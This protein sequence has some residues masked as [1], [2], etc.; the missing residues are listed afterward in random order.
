MLEATIAA[1]AT[2]DAAARAFGLSARLAESEAARNRQLLTAATLPAVDRYTG[3]LYDALDA[4]TLSEPARNWLGQHVRVHSALFGLVGGLDQ[5]PAY[6]C[7]HDSR[8]GVALRRHWH[9]LIAD[10]LGGDFVVDLRSEA[11]CHLGPASP[12]RS[13]YVRVV[14]DD[15]SGR[16]RALNHFNK[17]GKGAFVRSL[18]Q[19]GADAVDSA[20]DLIEVA[21]AAGWRM[22]A[23]FTGEVA[24]IV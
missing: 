1:S 16:R 6:R 20:A 15:G 8:V 9:T 18:A 14:T 17:H 2:A 10:E 24:L 4:G 21:A 3:V 5:I 22:D 19:L 13:V 23:T 12:E 11:Y 7:S